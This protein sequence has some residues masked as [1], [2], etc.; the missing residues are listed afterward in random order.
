MNA[1]RQALGMVGA[2]FILFAYVA[3]QM[4]RMNT[5]RPLYNALNTVGG[6]ILAYLACSPLQIGFLVLEGTWAFVSAWALVKSLR[7][8]SAA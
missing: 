1:A 6:I 3:Q 5:A 8:G 7:Q 2:A 4:R